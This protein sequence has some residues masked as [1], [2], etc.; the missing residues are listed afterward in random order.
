MNEVRKILYVSGSRADY[1]PIRDLLREID[2]QPN[3]ELSL[4][5]TA[6]HL[7]PEHGM[8]KTEIERDGFHIAAQVETGVEDGKL[9]SFSTFVGQTMIGI[10]EVI[11]CQSP[12]ILLLLGD[13]AEQLSA[14]VAGAIQNVTIAHL[15]GGTNSGSIDGSFRH[16]ISKFAH[17][18]LPASQPHADRLI[19]LGEQPDT[20][21]VVGLPGG[22]LGK[23]VTHTPEDIRNHYGL[24]FGKPYLLVL[25]HP[26]THS[27][28]DAGRQI[29][30]TLD[31]VVEMGLPTL[32]ANPNGD[33]GGTKVLEIMTSYASS[34]DELYLL[35]PPA[36][37]QLFASVMAHSA[38][39]V[40]NS[41]SAVYE[42]MSVGL[43]VVNIGDRQFGR[44]NESVWVNV[45]YDRQEIVDGIKAAMFDEEYRSCLRKYSSALGAYN[46]EAQV[47]KILAELD[48]SRSS[49]PKKFFDIALK[50]DR[51]II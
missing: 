43:P 29:R 10:A 47:V 46:P 23:H 4:L 15:C 18:H 51:S 24:P 16:A 33:P 22:H 20:I 41:S 34:F 25:Q 39:L 7:K 8:T 1:G 48:L 19:Q 40:G 27:H 21:H 50:Q 11:E 5:V 44:E 45:G 13:R 12:D 28:Q 49:H 26:V 36:D 2:S 17:Y 14:A 32:L 30:E 42:A 37:R 38:V 3:F 35:P 6:M 31:A 9:V